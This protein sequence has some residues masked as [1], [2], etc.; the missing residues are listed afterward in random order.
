[1]ENVALDKDIEI[2]DLIG[3]G[4]GPSNLA[5]SITNHDLKNVCKSIFLEKNTAF[6]WHSGMLFDDATMQVSFLKDLATF[7]NPRSYFTFLNYLYENERLVDFSNLQTF[8]PTRIEF[9]DYL[10]WCAN[11][12]SEL[13]KYGHEVVS[14]DLFFDDSRNQYIYAV[15]ANIGLS[16][17]K[18]FTKSIVHSTGLTPKIPDT[19][20]ESFR[21]FHGYNFLHALKD[22]KV[23]NDTSEH[24][25]VVGGGQSAAE[26]VE[27]LH[28]QYS[29]C[30]ITV[31]MPQFGYIPADNSPFVNQIFDPIHVDTFFMGDQ[32][33][34]ERILHAHAS[35]NYNASD[36]ELIERL[37]F[38]WYQGKVKGLQRFDLRRCMYLTSAISNDKFVELSLKNILNS[39]KEIFNVDFLICATGFRTRSP[40]SLMSDKLKSLLKYDS[41]FNI[42]HD[43]NYRLKFLNSPPLPP[44]YSVGTSEYEHGL[45]TTLISNMAVRSEEIL[46]DLIQYLSD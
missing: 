44:F 10:K 20:E 24:F 43:R 29:K 14:I 22:R 25:A 18:Y 23:S 9:F 42:A 3:I 27:F 38:L 40:A 17:V 30:S 35:T 8:F 11:S 6:S 7:R 4:F 28:N 31:I 36:I 1:M 37:Y 12:F 19:I 46:A 5:L 21:V 34:K 16:S 2:Y 41:E 15:T 39:E 26:I 13:V 33:G 32:E 45:S